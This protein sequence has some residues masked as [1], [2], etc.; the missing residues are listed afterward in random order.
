MLRSLHIVAIKNLTSIALGVPD[1]H[2]TWGADQLDS[3][4]IESLP[5]RIF[6]GMQLSDDKQHPLFFF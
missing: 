4:N 5:G 3:V 2:R 1:N 6:Q